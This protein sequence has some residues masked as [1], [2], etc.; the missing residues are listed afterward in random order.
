[1][2]VDCRYRL[3]RLCLVG[4]SK[5]ILIERKDQTMMS[6]DR[7]LDQIREFEEVSPAH[8]GMHPLPRNA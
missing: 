6:P 3:D 2:G 5:E 4:G 1:M 7:F 8:A